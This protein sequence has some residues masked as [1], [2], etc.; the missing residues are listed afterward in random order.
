MEKRKYFHS[1]DEIENLIYVS[2]AR[3]TEIFQ[4]V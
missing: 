4:K 2:V 3:L 1:M